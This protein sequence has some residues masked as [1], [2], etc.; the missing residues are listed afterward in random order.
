MAA[1]LRPSPWQMRGFGL[2]SRTLFGQQVVRRDAPAPM[3]LSGVII[4]RS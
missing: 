3:T 2:A 4:R 1:Q